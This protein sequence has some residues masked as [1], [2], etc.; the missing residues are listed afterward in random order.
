[1]TKP[2]RWLAALLV[3]LRAEAAR[4]RNQSFAGAGTQLAQI[5]VRWRAALSGIVLLALADLANGASPLARLKAAAT[6]PHSRGYVVGDLTFAAYDGDEKIDCPEGL[7]LTPV[8][9]FNALLPPEMSAQAVRRDSSGQLPLARVSRGLVKENGQASAEDRAA[10]LRHNQCT[11]PEEFPTY[12]GHKILSHRGPA[13]GLDLD[14]QEDS[15]DGKPAPGTCAH[16]DFNGPNGERGIDNQL[17]RVMGCAKG[18]RYNGDFR[19]N[20]NSRIRQGAPNT[21]IEITGLDDEKNDPEVTVDVY[22]G[23][24][25]VP[26]DASGNVLPGG[27][28]H[29]REEPKYHARLKG[30][31]ENGVVLTEPGTITLRRLGLARNPPTD[32]TLTSGRLRLELLPDGGGK[33]LLAGYYNVEEL[34]TAAVGGIGIAASQVF[35]YTCPGMLDQMRKFADGDPDPKSGRCRSISMAWEILA[36]PAFIIHSKDSD[37]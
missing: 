36:V 9:S 4:L 33:G 37:G 30:R 18:L 15:K 1:M 17:W 14:G 19:R 29:V 10:Y 3:S 11:N 2:M 35:G 13:V 24:D 31:I 27:S 12:T 16:D 22:Q 26:L 8:E 25:P 7:T 32:I 23:A 5:P 28:L 34:F 6:A 21:L 20:D